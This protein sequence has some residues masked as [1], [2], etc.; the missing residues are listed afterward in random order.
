MGP[1]ESTANVQKHGVSFERAGSVFLDPKALSIFDDEHSSLKEDRWN[2]WAL[3]KRDFCWWC[4][5]RLKQK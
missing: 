3:I 1:A 5:T 4:A 2:N